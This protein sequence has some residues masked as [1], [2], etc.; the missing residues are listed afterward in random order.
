M[1]RHNGVA[2]IHE[3]V[4]VN[5]SRQKKVRASE[6]R[7]SKETAAAH[8]A[9]QPPAEAEHNAYERANQ[10]KHR[11]LGLAILHSPLFIRAWNPAEHSPRH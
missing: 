5:E 9:E 11:H 10:R 8:E 6:E 2:A 7:T 1:P 3:S 4:N